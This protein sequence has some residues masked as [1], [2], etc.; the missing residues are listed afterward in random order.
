M[1]LKHCIFGHRLELYWV[2]FCNVFH[3][4]TL[5]LIVLCDEIKEN[6]VGGTCSMYRGDKICTHNFNLKTAREE[7]TSET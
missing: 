5:Y 2:H 1:Q 3:I 6:E 4:Y 7:T